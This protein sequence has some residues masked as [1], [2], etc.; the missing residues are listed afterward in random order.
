LFFLVTG[1]APTRDNCLSVAARCLETLTPST[2]PADDP[3]GK[4]QFAGKFPRIDEVSPEKYAD[5]PTL[6]CSSNPTEI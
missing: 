3:P 4:T 2:L 5:Q 1:N 6:S